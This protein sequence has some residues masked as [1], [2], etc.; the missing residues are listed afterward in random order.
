MSNKDVGLIILLK[1]MPNR[2]ATIKHVAPQKLLF[3]CNDVFQITTFL[4][5]F[6]KIN[7]HVVSDKSM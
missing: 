3:L 7:N 4:K 2:V 5:D 1:K 6:E